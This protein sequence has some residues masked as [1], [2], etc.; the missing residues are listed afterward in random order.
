MAV[1]GFSGS[2]PTPT[3][4]QF[5]ADVK[6]GKIGYYVVQNNN[7]R[8]GNGNGDNGNGNREPGA[9]AGG[10]RDRQQGGGQNPADQP[11]RQ[12]AQPEQGAQGGPGNQGGFGRNQH[13]DIT[14]WVTATFTPQQIGNTTIYKLTGHTG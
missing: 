11:A 9:A 5:Q 2:D 3:L 4:A 13:T 12:G 14:D 6:A 10:E 1:G 8:G 7:D